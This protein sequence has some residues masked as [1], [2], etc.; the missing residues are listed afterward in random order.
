MTAQM[1]VDLICYSLGF[2]GM[3]VYLSYLIITGR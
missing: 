3:L 1:W 2:G